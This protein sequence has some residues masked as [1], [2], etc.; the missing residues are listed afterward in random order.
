[1]PVP[2][3]RSKSRTGF[4]SDGAGGGTGDVTITRGQESYVFPGQ[5]ASCQR[6]IADPGTLQTRIYRKSAPRRKRKAE[7]R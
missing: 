1:M 4:S 6:R 3:K 5:D 2:S 7:R